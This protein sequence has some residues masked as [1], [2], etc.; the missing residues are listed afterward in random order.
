MDW[1]RGGSLGNFSGQRA[2]RSGTE[3]DRPRQFC[4]GETVGFTPAKRSGTFAGRTLYR[5][6]SQNLLQ[7]GVTQRFL[8]E[9][10]RRQKEIAKTPWLPKEPKPDA[11]IPAL[12]T[13]GE[14]HPSPSKRQASPLPLRSPT[15]RRSPSPPQR[16]PRGTEIP[17]VHHSGLAADPSDYKPGWRN[18]LVNKT[19]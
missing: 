5:P 19:Y 12:T 17:P 16:Q 11:L 7:V 2:I 4:Q 15:Q 3:P 18:N 10:S 6:N 14:R 9:F 13:S 1:V 8:S